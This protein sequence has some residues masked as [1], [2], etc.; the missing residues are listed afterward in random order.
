MGQLS[1]EQEF[2][3]SLSLGALHKADPAL[4]A[5]HEMR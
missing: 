2:L 1:S 5:H 4:G 3:P